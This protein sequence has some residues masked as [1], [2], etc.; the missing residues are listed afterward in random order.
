[1]DEQKRNLNVG[2][3]AVVLGNVSGDFGDGSV[4]IG[5]T[6]ERGNVILNQPMAVGRC[7]H[8]GPGSIAIGA[9]AGAGST[10][11]LAVSE[12]VA[13]IDR[14]KNSLGLPSEKMHELLCKLETIQAITS[15][16][17]PDET[18]LKQVLHSLRAIFE[19][20]VGS[21][22]ILLIDRLTGRL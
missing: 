18:K 17:Q 21:G 10:S 5:A 3:D 15:S 22:I 11:M 2:K 19:S 20:A 6:D 9:F 1:M 4:V 13:E 8:A 12:L 16:P 14:V 7:A